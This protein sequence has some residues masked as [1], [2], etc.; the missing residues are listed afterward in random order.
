VSKV[1]WVPA[2]HPTRGGAQTEGADRPAGD[3]PP[4]SVLV[5]Q[6][7][8]ANTSLALAALPPAAVMSVR[9]AYAREVARRLP[10]LESA[11]SSLTGGGAPVDIEAAVRDAHSL[12][13][14][15]AVV[16]EPTAATAL[17][18]MEGLLAEGSFDEAARHLDVVALSL[19]PWRS[20]N[21]PA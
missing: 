12:A 13:S 11:L 15:S 14:S 4:V 1:D 10:A 3:V 19:G 6:Q 7:R 5:P 2:V 9:A 18:A 8:R 16:G 20:G 21:V 17:R